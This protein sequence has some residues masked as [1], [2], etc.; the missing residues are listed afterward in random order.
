M[1]DKLLLSLLLLPLCQPCMAESIHGQ[2]TDPE[3]AVVASAWVTLYS[4][5][6]VEIGRTQTAANGA[7]EFPRVAPGGYLLEA[8]ADALSAALR[9]VRVAAGESAEVALRLALARVLQRVSVTASST[10]L[11][12]D[13]AAKALD[14]IPREDMERRGEFS[15]AEVLRQVPGMR[16]QQL[17]GPGAF[18]R[19]HTRGLRAL[20]TALLIDGF[21]IR[22]AASPQGDASA[23][24]SDLLVVNPARVE[25]L[26]GSGS[27]LYGTH[28]MAGV[29]QLLTDPGGGPLHGE[30]AA[31]G[32]GLGMFRGLVRAS[33]SGWRNRLQYSAGLAHLNVSGGTDGY[34]PARNTSAQAYGQLVLGPRTRLSSRLFASDAFSQLNSTPFAGPANLPAAGLIRARPLTGDALRRADAGG[35][36]DWSGANVAPSLNDPDARRSGYQVSTLTGLTH[37]LRPQTSIRL[38]YQA[39]VTS[40]DNR[41]G[42][43]GAYFPPPFNNAARYDAS[44]HNVQARLDT[45]LGR[46]QLVSAGWEWEQERFENIASDE[47][48]NP[49]QRVLAR[50]G[51]RQRAQSVFAQ[52]QLRLLDQRLQINVSGRWQGFSLAAPSF[53]G[54]SAAYDRTAVQGL[55]DAYTGDLAIAYLARRTG[56]K[57]RAHAGNAYRAP[58]L[59][60]RFGTYFFGGG[61]FALGDPRLS[62]E[63][64]LSFDG[65]FDQYFANSRLRVSGTY[66]YTRLQNVIA[67]GTLRGQD[68]FGRFSGYLN[69]RGGLARGVE[70]SAEAAIT[71]STRVLA[72][73]TY[74]RAQERTPLLAGG[75]LVSPRVPRQ[76][77]TWMLTQRLGKRIEVTADMFVAGESVTPLFAGGQT[78]GFVFA[79]PR[80]ADVALRYTHPLNDRVSLQWFTRVDNVLNRAWYEDGFRVPGIWAVGGMRLLF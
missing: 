19:I 5:S 31:E 28:A 60:E 39:L 20:D 46:R 55:P 35:P 40:R 17:G 49:A 16:V 80:K 56:T 78:R 72:S 76:M 53:T 68:P 42:P 37:Q 70:V 74:T 64:A 77:G 23:F 43:G 10:A 47:N 11:E 26:R 58:A 44:I 71:R 33:G 51:V 12:G 18:T 15:L 13:A 3:G 45:T 59:Y 65:G 34:D 4:E 66:F 75:L 36:I 7:F 24:L 21:R 52:D 2:V 73:Y 8:Q 67:F 25:V 6:G 30:L 9:A 41:D 29:V 32:G 69:A 63:R 62:P 27:S 54:G 61:F 22:D 79:P 50:T 14:L 1:S 57:F 48:P 38:G